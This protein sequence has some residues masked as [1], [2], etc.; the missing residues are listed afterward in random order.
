MRNFKNVISVV[1]ALAL[2]FMMGAVSV[3]AAD[4]VQTTCYTSVVSVEEDNVEETE[5]AVA[6]TPQV[7]KQLANTGDAGL[8]VAGAV[9]AASAAAFVIS[10]RK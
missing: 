4:E 6:K 3:F 1:L 5:T 10:K 2:V 7:K 8:A 9:A